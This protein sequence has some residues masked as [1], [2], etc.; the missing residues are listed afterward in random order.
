MKLESKRLLMRP[1]ALEDKIE[2]FEYRSDEKT[3]R[4]QGWIPETITD[5]ELFIEKNEKQFNSPDTWFQF[6]ICLKSSHKIIGD[7]GV[8]FMGVDN[9]QVELGFTLNKDFHN[10]G[11]ASEAVTRLIDY[12]FKDSKKNRIIASVDPQNLSSIRLLERIGFRKDA[13]FIDYFEL[14]EKWPN[15]LIYT[16]IENEWSA[17]T[18]FFEK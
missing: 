11:Y 17:R 7:L 6:V 10:C 14:S 18:D 16:I 3:N 4:F 5:V 2:I 8:H 9:K 13:R 12:L 15:D 1:I